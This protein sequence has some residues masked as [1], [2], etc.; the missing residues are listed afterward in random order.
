M[1]PKQFLEV[2]RSLKSDWF[3]SYGN[4]DID[5]IYDGATDPNKWLT[6]PIRLMC[7]FKEA[8]GGGR[9]N[10]AEAILGDNGLLRVG[11]T[12]N[13]AMHNRT[14]EWLY[15]IESVFLGNRPDIEGDR[16]QNY[17]N[18]RETMLRSA[19][20]NIKKAE[21]IAYS[22][23]G[24]LHS[25]A[26]RDADY[27]RRQLALLDP[28]VVL[29]GYTFGVVREVLFPDAKKIAETEFSYRTTNGRIIIDYYHPGRKSRESYGP[30]IDE[31]QRIV[32]SGVSVM[33]NKSE[34]EKLNT[35]N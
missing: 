22:N 25:V 4:P 15:A 33:S 31:V 8:H 9:W 10:H 13:Q 23:S 7:L 27:L 3:A 11:G 29:C 21:G 32:A 14:V 35:P 6:S 34:G 30:L 5:F 20:V 24:D 12:A 16:S 19:W 2:D 17:K 28:K 26:K 18:A 1:T